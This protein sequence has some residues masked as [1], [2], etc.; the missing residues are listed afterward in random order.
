MTV[1]DT[2]YFMVG[3]AYGAWHPEDKYPGSGEQLSEWIKNGEWKLGN[4]SYIEE[5]PKYLKQLRVLNRVNIGDVLIA[6]KMDADFKNSW[7]KAI[8]ICTSPSTDGHGLGVNWI[9]DF[10]SQP[11]K[12]ESSYRQTIVKMSDNP[13]PRKIINEVIIPLL[14]DTK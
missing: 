8:G 4:R 6:K 1:A 9:K 5:S 11:I 2:Q 7:I 12:V 10:T 14:S 3:T 13:K